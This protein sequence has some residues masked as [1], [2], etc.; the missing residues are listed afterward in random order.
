[1]NRVTY[2]NIMGEE[3]WNSP[4]L[5]H[6]TMTVARDSPNLANG[7]SSLSQICNFEIKTCMYI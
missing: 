6:M 5:A 3:Q 2:M 1:M 4:D 7:G